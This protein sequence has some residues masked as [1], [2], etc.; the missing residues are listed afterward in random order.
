MV[1]T[2]DEAYEFATMC[3]ERNLSPGIMIEVPSAA[4]L[5]EQFLAEVDFFSIGTNDLTQYTMA[6]DR[7]SSRLAALT[8][9]WQPAVLRLIRLAAEA[10]R[11]AG[12]PVGV[13]GEAAADPL[14]ACVLIGLGISSLS[15]ATNAIPAV[16][17]SSG[18][19]RLKSA[20][21]SRVASSGH[22]TPGMQRNWR[23]NCSPDLHTEREPGALH[24]G[25]SM[26]RRSGLDGHLDGRPCGDEVEGL[27][28]PLERDVLGDEVADRD[29]ARGDVAQ[30]PT[31]M[32]GAE[33]LAP[34]M[35]NWR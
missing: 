28:C 18:R 6:A 8:D 2:V 4:L 11:K 23:A 30:R 35:C 9:P 7:M 19:S 14:L 27:R 13:C 1:A 17:C 29:P 31:V 33:P 20:G 22:A 3:R 32:L 12:K 25:S 16:G 21:R 15:M 10:G 26:C 24:P 34:W 5:A